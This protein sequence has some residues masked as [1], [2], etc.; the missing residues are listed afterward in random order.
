MREAF[1]KMAAQMHR[2]FP[3]FLQ[4]LQT[5]AEALLGDR[6]TSAYGL[7]DCPAMNRVVC[8][9]QTPGHPV[10]VSE[11]VDTRDVGHAFIGWHNSASG[12]PI[13][14]ILSSPEPKS[15]S[16]F[17]LTSLSLGVPTTGD[18]L[19]MFSTLL[20][21]GTPRPL[22]EGDEG[23]LLAWSI[24]CNKDLLLFEAKQHPP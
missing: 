5:E 6:R 7:D 23:Y 9:H 3:G 10:V 13:L 2:A 8:S 4:R 1:G 19:V 20:A 15:G 12:K 18:T 21:H 17:C 11:H 16:K 14:S 24:C 22:C